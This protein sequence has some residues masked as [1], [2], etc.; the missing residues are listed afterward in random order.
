MKR[1]DKFL[2]Q[3]PPPRIYGQRNLI[4]PRRNIFVKTWTWFDDLFQPTRRFVEK[5]ALV[6]LSAIGL[7]F[8]TF[9][10][11]SVDLW[12]RRAERAERTQSEIER[13]WA[14]LLVR[15]GGESGKGSSLNTLYL[16]H[17]PLYNVE[18]S[19]E[20]I[21]DW[22]QKRPEEQVKQAILP[23]AQTQQNATD[24]PDEGCVNTPIFSKLEMPADAKLR[25]SRNQLLLGKTI[26]RARFPR[27]EDVVFD[28][29]KLAAVTLY[30]DKFVRVSI[31]NSDLSGAVIHGQVEGLI[32]SKS[33]VSGSFVSQDGFGRIDFSNIS[34]TTVVLDASQVARDDT[35]KPVL[36]TRIPVANQG[37][38][39]WADRPPKITI[40]ADKGWKREPAAFLYEE[41]VI[42]CD[43]SNRL[44]PRQRW[45]D[46][47]WRLFGVSEKRRAEP[48]PRLV[49]A[50]STNG[51][52]THLTLAEAQSKYPDAYKADTLALN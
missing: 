20:N 41:N 9:M 51:R 50:T 52:C 40:M 28:D 44:E 43:T 24:E 31:L 38:W 13:A 39:F 6:H 49:P 32:I 33:D 36:L 26:R 22:K 16:N 29:A 2:R 34:D 18:L 42:I 25:E 30:S 27:F 35:N 8:I 12:D 15:L 3:G 10:Q 47:F 4:A 37:N 11:L 5:S 23:P 45:D 21:G 48:S 14:H 17:Q 7:A 46:Y 19:C 1:S